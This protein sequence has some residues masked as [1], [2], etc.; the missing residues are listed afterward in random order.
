MQLTRLEVQP[1][2]EL[3]LSLAIGGVAVGVEVRA[4]V[5]HEV[6]RVGTSCTDGVGAM[7]DAGN[8]LVI[9]QVED[10][11]KEFEP[12][13]LPVVYPFARFT[14]TL[15]IAAAPTAAIVPL[16]DNANAETVRGIAAEADS[17]YPRREERSRR[18]A[19]RSAAMTGTL[20]CLQ[21]QSASFPALL[22]PHK[23]HVSSL[24][25]R[26]RLVGHR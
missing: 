18:N 25:R 11:G 17:M 7:G 1:G 2:G 9:H 14:V 8:V 20:T 21:N 16:E 10:L 24:G 15:A 12:E 19:I 13:P 4:V 26:G 6:E 22:R 3:H 23:A 5:L